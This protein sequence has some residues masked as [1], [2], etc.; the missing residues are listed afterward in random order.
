MPVPW[1]DTDT[2]GEATYR[3]KLDLVEAEDA[4]GQ[5]EKP[6]VITLDRP[7]C[8][9]AGNDAKETAEIQVYSPDPALQQQLQAAV[10]KTVAVTGEGFTAHTAHHHRPIVV[11][12]KRI[13]AQ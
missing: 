8:L 4:N 12:V 7:A 5:K 9:P 10:G 1:R 2:A 11:D 6:F 13:S 3:G